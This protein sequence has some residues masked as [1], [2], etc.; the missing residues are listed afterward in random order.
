MA[1]FNFGVATEANIHEIFDCQDEI[2][3]KNDKGQLVLMED[4]SNA[5]TKE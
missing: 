5:D 4:S 2:W 3:I 1:L